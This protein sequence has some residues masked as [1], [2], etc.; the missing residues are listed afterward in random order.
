MIKVRSVAL[1]DAKYLVE[2][3]KPYVEETAITFDYSVPSIY[4]FE[5][6]N[7]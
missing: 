1:E 5:E 7:S 2:I 4:E 3:Y 6:K